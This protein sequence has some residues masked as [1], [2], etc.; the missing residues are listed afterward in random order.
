MAENAEI[1]IP[2]NQRTLTW[3]AAIYSVLCVI[4]IVGSFLFAGETVYLALTRSW[5]SLL[6]L[7]ETIVV[8]TCV[9]YFLGAVSTL[10]RGL[11]FGEPA[12][13]INKV[14]IVD[15]ASTYMVGQLAWDEIQRMHPWTMER[16]VL[17]NRFFKT[18]IARHPGFVIVLKDRAYLRGLSQIKSFWIKVD[19]ITGRG[20]WL[21]VPAKSLGV[22]PG[23]LM[24]QLNR[25]YIAEVRGAV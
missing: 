25:F 5:F 10:W 15:H 2:Y 17:P 7:L 3:L 12:I 23:E 6:G 1:S 24:A 14:G 21:F 8:G 18:P 9:P 20:R 22:T 13:V 4:A 19:D 11:R 16:R